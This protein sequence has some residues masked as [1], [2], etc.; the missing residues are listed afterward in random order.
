M[1]RLIGSIEIVNRE[2]G[3]IE[4]M[5]RYIGENSWLDR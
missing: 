4:I 3:R 5:N 2:I 1:V